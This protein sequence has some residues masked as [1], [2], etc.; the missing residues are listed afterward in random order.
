[1]KGMPWI[2]TLFAIAA[3]YDGLLGL[4]FAVVP[5]WAFQA[6]GVTPP[7][8]WGYVQ[9]PALLLIVFGLMFLAIAVDP[10]RNRNLIPYGIGLKIA[11]CIVVFGYWITIGIPGMWKPFAIIDIIM[12]ALFVWAYVA[13]RKLPVADA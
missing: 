9:F 5:W 11:Y 13:I 2:R 1:M 3:V 8:H 12:A 10:R 6:A 7:N 4:M